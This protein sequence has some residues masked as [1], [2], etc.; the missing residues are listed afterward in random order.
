MRSVFVLASCFFMLA[1]F[2]QNGHGKTILP[3]PGKPI[4]IVE[5][6]CGECKFG[7]HGKSCDLAVRI[8]GKSYFVD[9]TGI[10]SPGDAHAKEGMCNAIRKAEVQGEI[11]DGRFKASYFKLIEPKNQK[12]LKKATKKA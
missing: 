6:A 9:G 4:Q 5:A 8:N 11:I 7:L 3:D 2:G 12:G 10:D 1:A